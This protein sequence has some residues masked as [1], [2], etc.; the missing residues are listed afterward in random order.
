MMRGKQTSIV[1]V[2]ACLFFVLIASGSGRAAG[3][4]V[5]GSVV[6]SGDGTSWATAFKTITEGINA[7]S[8][9]AT[10]NVAAGT[11]QERLVID[12][13]LTLTGADRDST[14]V[15]PTDTPQAGVYDVEIKASGTI[16]ENFQFDF[17]DATDTRSGNGIVVS[18]LNQ[19]PVTNV[20][21]RNNK[22][23][24]GD[25]NTGIQT[26][27][28]S[29]VSG[30]VVS[31]N[32]FYG[33]PDGMGE[34][35]YVN[36]YSGAGKVTIQGNEFY[37]YL[38]SGVSIEAG[39]VEVLGN[40]INSDVLKGIYGVR[41]IELTGG[42]AF[43]NVLISNNDIS[44]VQYGI[45][46]G[47][48]SDVGST[49]TATVRSNKLT[50]ND[51]GLRVRYGADLAVTNNNISGNTQYGINNETTALVIAENNWWGD[52]TG[53]Y[54][55]VTNPTGTGDTVSDN[56][57]YDPW[58]T[59]A[60][61]DF[62][63]VPTTGVRPLTVTFTDSSTGPV[64]TWSWD[65]NND[66]IE[67]STEQNPMYTYA[68]AGTYTVS[69]TISGPAG[70]STQTKTDYITVNEPPPPVANF[71]GNPTSGYRPLTVQFT[72]S[73]TG[74]ITS[75]SW[76][77]GDGG[78]S[79][80]QNPSYVYNGTGTF[81]VSLT[82][83]GPGGSNMQTKTGY[84]HVTEAP[85]EANFTANP[86]SGIKPLTVQFT[87]TSA[88]VVTVWS[89]AFGDGGTSTSKNPSHIYTIPGLYT[90]TLT[91][92][93]PGGSDQEV[94]AGYI[95]VNELPPAADFSAN[96][97]SGVK[98]L[99]VEFT[100]KSVNPVTSWLWDFGDG[101]TSTAQNPY[102]TYNSIGTY[103]V[104]L[105]VT[106]PGG[107]DVE[108]KIDY[109]R[110]ADIVVDHSSGNV[111]FPQVAADGDG[112]V[113][114]VWEDTRN[115]SKDIYL[116][117]SSDYGFTWHFSDVRLDTDSPGSADSTS[118]QIVCDSNGHVY[119]VWK[120]TRNGNPDIYFNYSSDYGVT[121]QSAD[122]K[123]GDIPYTPNPQSPKVSCDNAGHVY[124]A[125]NN[126]LFNTSAD[127]GATWLSQ[128]LR[129]STVGGEE[130]QL[131]SDQSGRVYAAWLFGTTDVLFNYSLDYGAT[132]QSSNRRIS[133]TG[134]LPYSISLTSDESGNVFCAWHD[135]RTNPDSPDVY[136]NS[137]SDYGNTWQAADLK[138]NTGTPGATYSIWPVID[139]DE[140]GRVYAAW[141]DR[142]NGI[143]DIYLNY[144]LDYGASWQAQDLR[145]DNSSGS[146]DS[147]DPVIATDNS[148]HVYVMWNDDQGNG[149]GFYVNYSLD[150]GASWLSENRKIGLG[151]IHPQLATDGSRFYAVSDNGSDILFNEVA[152]A[153][154]PPYL[155]ADP[156]PAYGADQISL[157][158]LLSWR[159]G[160][161]NLDDILTYD[162]YF[163]TSS[164]P[165]L[166]ASGVADTAYLPG[167]LNYFSTYYWQVVAKDGTSETAGP[168]W[169]FT[170]MSGP[171]QLSN[172]SPA[173]GEG[174]VSRNTILRWTGTDPDPGDTLTYS[175][176]FGKTNPPA[177]QASGYTSTTYSPGLLTHY[178]VYYWKI[179]ARDSHGTQTSGPVLS[180]TTINNSPQFQTFSPEDGATGVDLTTV[181]SWY[182]SD[183]DADQIEY[184]V[185]FGRSS[186]PPLV[187]S[188]QT[189]RTYV[190]TKL[191]A[192]TTYHWYVVARDEHGAETSLPPLSF[193]TLNHPP[194][195]L[196]LWPA[197]GL[198]VSAAPDFSLTWSAHD[199]DGEDVT[200]DVYFG[201]S[202]PPPQVA[203]H[204]TAESFQTGLLSE[205]TRYY[206]K[207]VARDPHGAQS[208]LPDL[209]FDASSAAPVF[210]SFTPVDQ[211]TGVNTGITLRWSASD[212]D[213]NDTLTYDIY[214]GTSNPPPLLASN[215]TVQHY[216]TKNPLSYH[217]V[218]Y[219]KVVARDNHGDETV[220]PILHFTTW[221]LPHIDYIEP[222]P[223]E[224]KQVVSIYGQR[225]GD[226]QFISEIHLGKKQVFKR[227][228]ANILLWGNNRIDFK[229]PAYAKWPHDV[230]R[231]KKLWIRVPQFGLSNK[232][233][234]AI[235]KP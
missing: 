153:P 229:V 120:D 33:D 90:V 8:A 193:T 128:A 14:I 160:D 5:D 96:R 72:D 10:V 204:Q 46:V 169:S 48:S 107:T 218:Y 108:T 173:N 56:V 35:V 183:A 15:Q 161:A 63:A 211:D 52:A 93:G 185:Y 16:I 91:A 155:P 123:L 228:S 156:S 51:V 136:F 198:K 22:I 23:Y 2:L 81:T 6:S 59:A 54:H 148:G 129:I 146:G 36:P 64:D 151:G 66:T 112:N 34:G 94:K 137:S 20:Q 109:I 79:T 174:G 13:Q 232:I 220:S 38:Y 180:F 179:V 134:A 98:P 175:V 133:N 126:N 233:P 49:L 116:N 40:T 216:Q 215:V 199:Q 119:A 1:T 206:W 202:S 145:L 177:L 158:P 132:W 45:S 30:L 121:W 196:N 82:V 44:D 114:V 178:T 187:A 139:S 65:F 74:M 149:P 42:V 29:D 234:L 85:P 164:P 92:S 231:T 27:K 127:Y 50:N 192:M 168:I 55:A 88:G 130:T 163:G 7:V 100:D 221:Q 135:G 32:I 9:G 230:T 73:S 89:W 141:H 47:T 69:L 162:I 99:T 225:F 143:G 219:W 113:Y 12:K 104:T 209:Y 186:P 222:N 78:T 150:Y 75:W 39:N 224:T 176:Y 61:A 235:Y 122:K 195:F 147:G 138:L 24:T 76:D 223:C 25:G 152:P 3:W 181:L 28:Y 21:I 171:P 226:T 201:T 110:I 207:V 19:P 203:S 86:T 37:G 125:W 67:D 103:T 87:D 165:P 26:G 117:Y 53:P 101:G 77:F 144:S 170:T 4:Y 159:C 142:R 194:E 102:H 188:N 197:N 60:Q 83:M 62:T 68:A 190:P 154:V 227:G 200:Y 80:E 58:I 41:F 18:D 111:D 11:Y 166:V 210:D 205:F 95:T 115:G 208:S 191:K 31:G 167:T 70:S 213:P 84:I 43:S 124:A 182:A 172:F 71:S 105:T 214:L 157:T 131:T 106:G 140:G 118:P 189:S 97:T 184:D 212:P 17:N 57:D 217:T